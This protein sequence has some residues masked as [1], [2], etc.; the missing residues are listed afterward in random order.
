MQVLNAFSING[1]GGNPAGV[2]FDAD[3]LTASQKQAIATKAGFPETAFVSNSSMADF[4]LD[5]FTPN[6]QIAHCGHATIATF[7]FLKSQGRIAG[8]ESSKE[9]V[10]GRR[11]IL[12]KQGRAFMEQQAP[13]FTSVKDKEPVLRSLGISREELIPGI[14]V[15]IANSGNSFLLVP[16]RDEGVLSRIVYDREA[17]YRISAEY[18]LIGY[19]VYTKTEGLDASTRM[20][21]PYYGIEEEAGTGMAAGPLATWLWEQGANDRTM[22]RI[23]QG[24]FMSPPSPSQV[25][26]ELE[27]RNGR[28]QRLFAGGGAHLSREL[29]IEI[30]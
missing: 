12:F 5:F 16:V 18:G 1:E 22:F 15:V 14:D 29:T 30:P 24:R 23:G 9:T 27:L 2:V 20:F 26:V 21:G 10:D 4:K 28:M 17:V 7:S 3:G 6:R 11:N 13:I 8:D 19:Y 25:E